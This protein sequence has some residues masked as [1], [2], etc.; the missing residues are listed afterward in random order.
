MRTLV[1][2]SVLCAG[3]APPEAPAELAELSNYLYR[4]WDARDAAVPAA[5]LTNLAAFLVDVEL[6]SGR[7]DDRAWLLDPLEEADVEGIERPNRNLADC[8]A[9]AVAGFSRWP[10]EDHARLQSEPDQTVTEPTSPRYER[11]FP[12]TDDPACFEE[13][14]CD[15]LVTFNDA[16]R[17][18]I[19]L[20]TTF[21]LFKDFRWL[22][23]T[24]PDGEERDAFYS[25]SWFEDSFEGDRGKNTLWQS[26][27]VDVWLDRGDGT[28]WRYQTLWSESE[29]EGASGEGVLT[30]AVK[31]GT[32]GIYQAGDKAIGELYH[33]E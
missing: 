24:D 12:E 26:Y 32:N 11:S 15:Q 29:I 27:S 2:W 28:A 5:G 1:L 25:R 18:N 19:V 31:I 4:E 22:T 8:L 17:A 13:R 7:I 21:E 33:G 3:C 10:V 20:S 30:G 14:R 9:V 16:E 6:D 23:Y